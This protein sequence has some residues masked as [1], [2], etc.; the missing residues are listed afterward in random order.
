MRDRPAMT[1]ENKNF[2]RPPPRPFFSFL[3]FR[4]SRTLTLKI[5]HNDNHLRRHLPAACQALRRSDPRPDRRHGAGRRRR[6]LARDRHSHSFPGR[7]AGKVW[8]GWRWGRRRRG[9]LMFYECVRERE[10]CISG[11]ALAA[12]PFVIFPL[13]FPFF[14]PLYLRGRVSPLSLSRCSY[15]C[16][17]AAAPSLL[18]AP[19]PPRPSSPSRPQSCRPASA[20]PPSPPRPRPAPGATSRPRPPRPRERRRPRLL[21]MHWHRRNRTKSPRSPTGPRASPPA[22]S[23][24]ATTSLPSECGGARQGER[25]GRRS[26]LK[27]KRKGICFLSRWILRRRRRR[28]SRSLSRSIILTPILSHTH[29][30]QQDLRLPRGVGQDRRL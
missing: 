10:R 13:C 3:T 26:L 18:L 29:S 14:S 8:R 9:Q 19:A 23:S 21:R 17:A 28:R 27:G 6:F 20:P 2:S 22:G 30:P 5:G 16:S 25:G 12:E 11:G 4:L 7:V 24:T 15:C 1:E